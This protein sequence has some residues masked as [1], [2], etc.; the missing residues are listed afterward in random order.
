M[1]ILWYFLTFVSGAIGVLALVRVIERFA[2]GAGADTVQIGIA[3]IFL[4][5][6]WQ[7]LQ[8]ARFKSVAVS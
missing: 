1:N 4:F 5:L 6:A 8:K 2:V 3:L 7:S